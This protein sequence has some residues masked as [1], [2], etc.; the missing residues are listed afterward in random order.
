MY[1]CPAC[2]SIMD[3]STCRC[4][5]QIPCFDGIWQLT[6]MPDMIIDGDGDKYIGYEHIGESY[7]GARK[8]L[9]EERDALFAMEI[10]RLTGDGIFLD[11]ACGDGCFTVPCAANGTRIVA[12]DISN[13]MLS[14]LQKK[15]KLNGIPL[16]KVTL[17]RMNALDLPLADETVDTVVAN[18]VLHL[19]SNPQKVITEIYR[20]LKKGGIFLCGEDAPGKNTSSIFDNS[21]YN[22]IVNTL[23]R[24]YWN[25]L[26]EYGIYPKRYRWDFDRDTICNSMFGKMDEKTIQRNATYEIP[27]KDGFLPRFLG[28]GFSDQVDV[29][30]KLHDQVTSTL[31]LEFKERY[32]PD[33]ADVSYKGVEDDLRIIAYYKL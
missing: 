32:G 11:L 5:H 2:K 33:F 4:G 3:L 27:L 19:I 9:I 12:A 28:R 21:K 17:C 18:S 25:R 1:L 15:A 29:P 13:T 24:E 6:D 26:K 8:Y 23:Y 16:N 22:E 20:V 7:S 30:S 10:S 31:I 14:I